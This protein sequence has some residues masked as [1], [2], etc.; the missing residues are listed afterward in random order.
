MKRIIA[1]VLAL[2]LLLGL[3]MVSTGAA[4]GEPMVSPSLAPISTPARNP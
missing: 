4:E 2:C 3:G 1:L